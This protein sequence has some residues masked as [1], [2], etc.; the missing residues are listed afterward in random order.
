MKALADVSQQFLVDIVDRGWQLT[1]H[2][3]G[4]L[5]KSAWEKEERAHLILRTTP[6]SGERGE[7]HESG[8]KV[9]VTKSL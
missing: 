4:N 8:L 1:E 2:N 7:Y 9:R 5:G 6:A 3:A